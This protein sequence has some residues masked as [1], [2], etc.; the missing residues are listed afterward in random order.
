MASSKITH[1]GRLRISAPNDGRAVKVNGK[2]CRRKWP[3]SN[4]TYY[5]DVRIGEMRKQRGSVGN[6]YP[7][8]E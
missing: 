5:P 6:W 3:W 1:P 8:R 7:D 2:G 4:L